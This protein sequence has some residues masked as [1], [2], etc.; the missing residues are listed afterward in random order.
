MR[1]FVAISTPPDGPVPA[2]LDECRQRLSNGHPDVKWV[3]AHQRHITL[4]FLGDIAP[5]AIEE[6]RSTLAASAA[7]C[8]PFAAALTGW[9]A[10]P[11]PLRPQTLWVGADAPGDAFK[12][13]E[14]ALTS[15][16]KAIGIPPEPKRFHPHVTLGR[17]RSQQGIDALVKSLRQVPPT[18]DGTEFAVDRLILFESV[19]SPAGPKYTVLM[20]APLGADRKI[21]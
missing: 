16:L 1:T 10:F 8:G 2:Y 4:R 12:G 19:L 21:V 15:G 5:E 9:G 11:N 14:A 13:L 7:A 3:A 20:E 17:V 6:V 18:A